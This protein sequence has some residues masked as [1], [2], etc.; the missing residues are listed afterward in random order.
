MTERIAQTIGD[1]R[2]CA[3]NAVDEIILEA[4]TEIADILDEGDVDELKGKVGG[5]TADQLR[6]IKSHADR[7][8][9][10]SWIVGEAREDI[11]LAFLDLNRMNISS[12]RKKFPNAYRKWTEDEDK[13]LVR[14]YN[15][16]MAWP[17]MSL[18]FGRNVNALKIRLQTLGFEIP[19]ARRH[20]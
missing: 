9:L 19:D 1:Y 5:F 16:G 2:E 6:E 3:F 10:D 13:D 4:F 18:R 12:F 14:L 20:Y 15:E 11:E 17:D 8:E 7:L